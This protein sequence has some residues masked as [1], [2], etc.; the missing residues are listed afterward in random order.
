MMIWKQRA[1]LVM[2]TARWAL[3]HPVYGIVILWS[4]IHTNRPN[5]SQLCSFISSTN[6]SILI[7]FIQENKLL[8]LVPCFQK[9][10]LLSTN[11]LFFLT[12]TCWPSRS[13]FLFPFGFI[14]K[15]T[16]I[17]THCYLWESFS[18]YT[19]IPIHDEPFFIYTSEL[20]FFMSHSL[21]TNPIH[22]QRFFVFPNIHLWF[23]QKFLY[24]HS[25]L[26]HTRISFHTSFT[27]T[28]S[29]YSHFLFTYI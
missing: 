5:I 28:K 17:Y 19:Y 7:S 21:Y 16:K 26:T 2:A 22:V 14:F 24:I 6:S 9:I 20:F 4:G 18:L 10:R 11:D 23:I 13:F 27:H 15:F 12:I 3:K 8:A 29:F 25:L 1:K